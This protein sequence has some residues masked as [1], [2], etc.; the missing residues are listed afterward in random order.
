MQQGR[1]SDTFPC[2]GRGQRTCVGV[3]CVILLT[4]TRIFAFRCL[5]FACPANSSMMLLEIQS[6]SI[7]FSSFCVLPIRHFHPLHQAISILGYWWRKLV[8]ADIF[9]RRKPV[10]FPPCS[11]FACFLDLMLWRLDTICPSWHPRIP[12]C[13]LSVICSSFRILLF[14]RQYLVHTPS[15]DVQSLRNT[16][17]VNLWSIFWPLFF[18]TNL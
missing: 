2:Y 7:L 12:L 8:L 1:L 13:L 9:P 6:Q 15:H 10:S 14:Y 16:Q 3:G 17:I 11:F 4:N 5:S 18:C